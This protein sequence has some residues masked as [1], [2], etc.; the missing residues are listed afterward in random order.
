MDVVLL[1][2]L[3]GLAGPFGGGVVLRFC[4]V[5]ACS[6]VFDDFYVDGADNFIA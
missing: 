3:G 5:L 1:F 4:L 2:S 6:G